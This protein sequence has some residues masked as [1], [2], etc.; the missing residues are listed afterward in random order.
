[1]EFDLPNTA[2][3]KL[4]KSIPAAFDEER[5]IRLIKARPDM[6]LGRANLNQYEIE[7]IKKELL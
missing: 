2:I 3:S 7:R 6:I 1:M 4:D 5:F